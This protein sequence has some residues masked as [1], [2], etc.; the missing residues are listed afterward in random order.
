MI[1]NVSSVRD[2]QGNVLYSRSVWRDITNRKQAEVKLEQTV[3]ELVSSNSD[4]EKFAYIASHDLKSPLLSISGFAGRLKKQY[5]DKLDKNAQE[6]IDI[7]VNSAERMGNL[8]NDLLSYSR[9]G[10][11]SSKLNPVDLNKILFRTI[12]NLSV[13]IEKYGAKVAHNSLPTVIGND[14]QLEQLMQNLIE[15]AIKF[16]SQ[17][18]PRVHISVEQKDENWIFSVKDNG[19]GIVSENRDQIFNMFEC[20]H[21][22]EYKGTGMGLA[23]CQRIV[24]I[25]GGR[26]WV[27]SELGNGSIFYFTIPV[28]QDL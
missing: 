22:G 9:I 23:T 24:E 6:Y 2:E 21:G 19:I 3:K 4:L 20:L 1:L 18:P 15:N 5:K 27:E 14:M 8:I 13:E 16:H 17:E 10:T 25:H 7:I 28:R 11:S 26:I 12:A